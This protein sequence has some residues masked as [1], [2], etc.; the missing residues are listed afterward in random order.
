MALLVPDPFELLEDRR[1]GLGEIL[2]ELRQPVALP[3]QEMA[4]I[5]PAEIGPD[6]DKPIDRV[7]E[8][9]RIPCPILGNQS[10]HEPILQEA[11]VVLAP[12]LPLGLVLVIAQN[13]DAGCA[14]HV[15]RRAIDSHR[16]AVAA[17]VAE[18]LQVGLGPVFVAIEL[19]E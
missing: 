18:L 2:A 1:L 15:E 7:V 14:G 19:V 17:I 11:I 9:L 16:E 5:L 10:K 3:E 4:R 6:A 13:R 8:A 12:E